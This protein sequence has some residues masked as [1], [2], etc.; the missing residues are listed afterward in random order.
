ME[1]SD[2]AG[3]GRI[4]P[5]PPGAVL[6]AEFMAPLGV[7]GRALARELGVPSSRITAILGGARRVTAETE[8]KPDGAVRDVGGVLA[9]PANDARSGSGA[10]AG[11]SGG[12]SGGASV[13]TRTEITHGTD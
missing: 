5:V 1:F 13:A 3:A 12:M 8:R 4:G 6:R 2:V 7:S 10:A 11:A 9:E